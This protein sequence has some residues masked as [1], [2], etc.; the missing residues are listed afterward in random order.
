MT[1]CAYSCT[2]YGLHT[3]HRLLTLA[4][5]WLCLQ[6][7]TIR[8]LCTVHA[9]NP[10]WCLAVPTAACSRVS[11]DSTCFWPMLLTCCAYSCKLKRL[12][13]TEFIRFFEPAY[14]STQ[15]Y[16]VILS[17]E[18]VYWISG[19][20]TYTAVTSFRP[21]SQRKCNVHSFHIVSHYEAQDNANPLSLM[22]HR[23]YSM[24]P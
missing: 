14:F 13:F 6:L 9:S 16:D 19:G 7:H 11:I 23:F 10:C 2:Q 8:S 21:Y 12:D 4:D 3:Q 5:N 20:F 15:D 17:G 18:Y 22:T 24:T 1:F